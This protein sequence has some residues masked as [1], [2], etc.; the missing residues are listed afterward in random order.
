M[1]LKVS[2]S[3]AMALIMDIAEDKQCHREAEQGVQEKNEADGDRCRKRTPVIFSWR[4]Y[5]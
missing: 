1:E 3:E 4:S 5:H 2:V